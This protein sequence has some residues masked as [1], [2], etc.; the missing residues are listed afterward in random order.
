MRVHTLLVLSY[1]LCACGGATQASSPGSASADSET[2][3][4]EWGDDWAW[5]DEETTAEEPSHRSAIEILGGINPPPTPWAE[6]S[7]EDREYYMVGVVNPITAEMMQT[8]N[9]GRATGFGCASC[10]GSNMRERD[11]A[12]PSTQ[13]MPIPPSGT[14]E[15]DAMRSNFGYIVPFMEE[16]FTVQVGQLLGIEDFTCNSCHPTTG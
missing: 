4:E 12:M 10:H 13:R 15:Y 2:E 6:M 16:Q 3:D 1:F 8:H 14:P 11:F 7:F 5:E 9:R